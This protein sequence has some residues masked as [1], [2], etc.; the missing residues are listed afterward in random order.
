MPPVEVTEGVLIA[1]SKAIDRAAS[2]GGRRLV[3]ATIRAEALDPSAMV[4]ASRL[5]SDRWFCWEQ[6]D[7]DGFA[8]GALGSAA[9]VVSRGAERFEQV[10]R[11]CGE[12]L[13]GAALSE[14]EGLPAGAGPVWTGGFAFAAEGGSQPQWSSLPPALMV[15]PELSL[16]RSGGECF[17]TLNA[18]V[19]G[20]RDAGEALARLERR[21]AGLRGT[22]IG[23][24]DPEPTARAEISSP[25]PP[26]RYELLV[27]EATRRIGEGGIE[28]AVLAREIL[29]TAAAAHDPAP[30]FGAL[31]ELF[32]SCFCFCA[33][34]PE[35]AFIGASPELLIRRR[36]P[37]AATVALAGSTRR[38]ADPAV[39]DHLGEQLLVSSKDRSEHEIV[40]RRIERA[41]R[42]HAVWIQREEDPTVVKVANIQ[43]LA[44]PIRAQLAQSHSA[45]SL[46][47]KLH[48]TPAV[49]GEPSDPAQRLIAEIEA[50]DRGWYAGPV[51]WM[52]ATEDGEFCVALRSALLRDRTA[53]LYTGAGIVADSD[54]AA[55]LAET[56]IK[57]E[58][59]LPL[60]AG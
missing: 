7:G 36:G 22:V 26:G 19:S 27:A 18:V 52:D 20:E 14:P 11:D 21:L 53:H 2:R 33:G 5:A 13:E 3:S 37:V 42:P 44:T 23:P 24:L 17:L 1:A 56:E 15:L 6:P 31:R 48:P 16:L 55:E 8:L 43:H 58:A 54:P 28:K 34:T 30:L 47:G 60:I 39:D 25:H 57:L 10:A 35:A 51:G 41:L 45:I 46:A 49:G 9:E 50:L 38:S 59:L 4:F 32:P 40:A 29:V 12:L